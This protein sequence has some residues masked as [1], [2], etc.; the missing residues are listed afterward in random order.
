MTLLSTR[1]DGYHSTWFVIVA[2][3]FVT[4][5]ITANIIAVK[6]FSVGPF[7]LPAAVII[8]PISYIFGDILTEVY[9]YSRA[10]RVIWLG[11][12]CNLVAVVAIWI[13]G[14]LPPV[15]PDSPPPRC[16]RRRL[17]RLL[18]CLAVEGLT[19]SLFP[20]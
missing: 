17:T 12:G 11:F 4:C 9:G 18:G 5:L 6:L 3:V 7:V 20:L 1:S 8:F 10:R 15:N 2:S 14:L 16:L 13:G 19:P